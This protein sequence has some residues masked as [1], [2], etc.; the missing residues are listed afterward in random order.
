MQPFA[1]DADALAPL[2]AVVAPTGADPEAGAECAV[3]ADR[4]PDERQS[5][6][7]EHLGGVS[8]LGLDVVGAHSLP[9]G[10]GVTMQEGESGGTPER[11][12]ERSVEVV[13]QE[14]RV[15][16]DVP[17]ALKRQDRLGDQCAHATRAATRVPEC[18]AEILLHVGAQQMPSELVEP[19]GGERRRVPHAASGNRMSAGSVS[20]SLRRKAR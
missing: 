9:A 12:L 19:L 5:G 15:P 10:P 16:V 13:R 8:L 20:K 2:A 11:E 17:L 3:G 7:G 18:E 6:R 4:E 1:D 14:V